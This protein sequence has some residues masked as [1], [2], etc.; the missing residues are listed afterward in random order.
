MDKDV[1]S[2]RP[3]N[4]QR[5]IQYLPETIFLTLIVAALAAGTTQQTNDSVQMQIA[6]QK[7]ISQNAKQ[8]SQT[9]TTLVE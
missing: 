9:A 2:Q 3:Q 7:E 5:L 8:V 6:T 4:A 1:I